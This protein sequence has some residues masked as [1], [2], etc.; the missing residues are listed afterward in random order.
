MLK[1]LENHI[2]YYSF[3]RGI[4]IYHM[5]TLHIRLYKSTKYVENKQSEK[6]PNLA[7]EDKPTIS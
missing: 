2:E 4:Y 5:S 3:L 7:E 1:K 6:D